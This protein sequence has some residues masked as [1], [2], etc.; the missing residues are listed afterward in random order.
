MRVEGDC[1]SN[2]EFR[3]PGPGF[4]GLG[5]GFQ[6]SFLGFRFSATWIWASVFGCRVSGFEFRGLS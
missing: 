6:A 4:R 2:S 5:F 3:V 1:V